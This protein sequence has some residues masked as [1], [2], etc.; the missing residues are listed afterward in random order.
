MVL[1]DEVIEVSAERRRARCRCRV[2]EESP[3]AA[4]GGVPPL[5]VVEMM[6]QSAACLKGYVELMKGL[7]VRPAYLVRMD[8]LSLG[9]AVTP[10]ETVEVAAQEVRGLGD[11][12]VYSAEAGSAA[13]A[14]AR[15]TLGFIV[16]TEA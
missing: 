8:E 2:S 14:S 7:P 6:V 4:A 5:L 15:G 13:G 3:L 12:F 11:Y 9:R 10:G 1:V 16:D